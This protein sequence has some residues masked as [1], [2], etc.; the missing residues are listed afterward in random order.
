[1]NSFKVISSNGG[2]FAAPINYEGWEPWDSKNARKRAFAVAVRNGEY[3]REDG[4]I[5]TLLPED[6]PSFG[7]SESEARTLA[8]RLDLGQG[9]ASRSRNGRRRR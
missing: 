4:G 3:F 8:R 6:G 1:M 9:R 5:R 2:F 7:L